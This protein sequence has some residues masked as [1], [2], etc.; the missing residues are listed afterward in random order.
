ML[1]LNEWNI[2][3]VCVA[4][5]TCTATVHGVKIIYVQPKGGEVAGSRRREGE[6]MGD[7]RKVCMNTAVRAANC[8]P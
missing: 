3:R 5:R 2:T 7:A 1:S 6:E 4:S 8:M